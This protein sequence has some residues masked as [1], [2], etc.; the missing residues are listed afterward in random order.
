MLTR[1][2]SY[3]TLHKK[4]KKGKSIKQYKESYTVEKSSMKIRPKSG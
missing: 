4:L 2:A 3:M 1:Y